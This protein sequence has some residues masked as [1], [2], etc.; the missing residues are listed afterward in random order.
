[1]R[2]A[3]RRVAGNGRNWRGSSVVV[4]VRPRCVAGVIVII[5]GRPQRRRGRCHCTTD[6]AGRYSAWPEATTM[7]THLCRCRGCSRQYGTTGQKHRRG[8]GQKFCSHNHS[9]GSGKFQLFRSRSVGDRIAAAALMTV[10]DCCSW[11]PGGLV[12][13]AVAKVPIAGEL[14]GATAREIDCKSCP[15][16]TDPVN[17]LPE[18]AID[19]RGFPLEPLEFTG[20]APPSSAGRRIGL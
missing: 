2:L 11:V 13:T 14:R 17:A 9:P 3:P 7:P 19:P 5:A 18:R 4:V 12:V 15:N 1:M 8:A 10:P 16:R 20:L 6:Y